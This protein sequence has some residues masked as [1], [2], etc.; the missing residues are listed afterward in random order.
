M[1]APDVTPTGLGAARWY[2]LPSDVLD[3]EVPGLLELED[4]LNTYT[5]RAKLRRVKPETIFQ[6]F[7]DSSAH[8]HML[9]RGLF[10]QNHRKVTLPRADG[11]WDQPDYVQRPRRLS[12]VRRRGGV[13]DLKLPDVPLLKAGYRRDF[14]AKVHGAV[15]QLRD[16]RD[17]ID[18][19]DPAVLAA[20]Q[21]QLGWIPRHPKLAVVIGLRQREDPDALRHR[22]ETLL[23][24]L[25]VDLVTYDDVLDRE[26]RRIV[27]QHSL[28]AG[29]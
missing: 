15:A 4:L 10:E 2:I 13:L 9:Y 3:R 19:R 14:S 27:L 23:R 11:R 18:K 6:E 5:D 28:T 20:L 22:E 8:A 29:H 12:S 17:R 1:L 25:D 21:R 16:Y 24:D 26:A 7:F